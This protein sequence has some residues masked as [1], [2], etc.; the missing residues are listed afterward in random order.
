M[1]EKQLTKLG[2]CVSI[3]TKFCRI[4]SNKL[5]W[6]CQGWTIYSVCCAQG[7]EKHVV[8]R[9]GCGITITRNL[10]EWPLTFLKISVIFALVKNNNKFEKCQWIILP[11]SEKYFAFWAWIT[12]TQDIFS[13]AE[14]A[15]KHPKYPCFC[16][17]PLEFE[18]KIDIHKHENSEVIYSN[19]NKSPKKMS[20]N[21]RLQNHG[22]YVNRFHRTKFTG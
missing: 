12:Q 3:H 22:K 16:M 15:W 20:E 8:T 4:M 2:M 10:A 18:V 11:L 14:A 5:I 13:L 21:S 1:D 7:G 17:L 6:T 9:K 19:R